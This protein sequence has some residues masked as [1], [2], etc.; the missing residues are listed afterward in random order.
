MKYCKTCGSSLRY[1]LTNIDREYD[2]TTGEL[3][4]ER[5]CY[6]GICIKSEKPIRERQFIFGLIFN[7]GVIA[8]FTSLSIKSI[9]DIIFFI[10]TLFLANSLLF[11][12]INLGSAHYEYFDTEKPIIIEKQNRK[13][14]WKMP[15]IFK[16]AIYLI[17]VLTAW[18]IYSNLENIVVFAISLVK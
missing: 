7:A 17:I 18:K 10:G 9:T 4:E 6:K 11:D 1:K 3:C 13:G 8:F 14:V 16:F 5:Y 12:I 15:R 2:D